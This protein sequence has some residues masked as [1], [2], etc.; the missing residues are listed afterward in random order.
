MQIRGLR[1]QWSYEAAWSRTRPE[2]GAKQSIHDLAHADLVG[3]PTL[4]TLARVHLKARPLYMCSMR[5]V[6]QDTIL[7]LDIIE[8]R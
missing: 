6:S 3:G 4:C 8:M 7:D 1:T 2:A 5:Q